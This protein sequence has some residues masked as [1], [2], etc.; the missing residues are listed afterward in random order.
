MWVKL[1][2]AEIRLA[3]MWCDSDGK[4]PSEIAALLHRDKLTVTLQLVLQRERRQDG[5]PKASTEAQV[6]AMVKKLEDLILKANPK[7]A[8]CRPVQGKS[9]NK[10][11]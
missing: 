4:R 1:S 9:D 10:A 2:S 6:D 8:P 11:K 3:H 5:R 7:V